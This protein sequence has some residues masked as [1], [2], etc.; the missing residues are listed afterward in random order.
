MCYE[1]CDAIV[2]G[3]LNYAMRFGHDIKSDVPITEELLYNIE[4]YLIPSLTRYDEDMY[5]TKIIAPT[6]SDPIKTEGAVGTGISCGG[7]SSDPSL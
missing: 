6:I 4:T 1:R 5:N 7:W 2:I 3:L